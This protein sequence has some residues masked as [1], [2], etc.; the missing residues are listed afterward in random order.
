MIEPAGHPEAEA[1]SWSLAGQGALA[2][3][4]WPGAIVEGAPGVA[5]AWRYLWVG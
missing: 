1:W 2:L 3:A 5:A 4:A